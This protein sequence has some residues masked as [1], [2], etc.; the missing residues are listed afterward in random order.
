MRDALARCRT[1]IVDCQDLRF[2]A[3]SAMAKC[4]RCTAHQEAQA[5][6]TAAHALAFVAFDVLGEDLRGAGGQR[7]VKG[8]CL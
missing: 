7:F 6:C 2:A 8:P 1:V 5:Q 3:A 4:K